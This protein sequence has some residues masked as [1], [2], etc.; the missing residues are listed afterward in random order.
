VDEF[1]VQGDAAML[2]A[3]PHH[4]RGWVHRPPRLL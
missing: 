1:S 2:P 4:M 3:A